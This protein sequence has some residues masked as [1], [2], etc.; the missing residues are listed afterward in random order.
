MELSSLEYQFSS[1]QNDEVFFIIEPLHFD[2]LLSKND[3]LVIKVTG[4][5]DTLNPKDYHL[6]FEPESNV[7][8][9]QDGSQELELEISLNQELI[10]Q[11][12]FP[13]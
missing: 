11:F 4:P 2:I 8:W 1:E 6:I 3:S 7:F 13:A 10:F 5:K 9:I 12:K